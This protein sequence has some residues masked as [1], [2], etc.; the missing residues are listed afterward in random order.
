MFREC[1]WRRPKGGRG[2]FF[3]HFLKVSNDGGRMV[4][5]C[6]FI[7]SFMFCIELKR[8]PCGAKVKIISFRRL[9]N[10]RNRDKYDF[11]IAYWLMLAGMGGA[12]LI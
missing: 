1:C 6:A 12:L 10:G 2:C 11:S 9:Q 4:S 5:I 7:Y 8:L 3:C